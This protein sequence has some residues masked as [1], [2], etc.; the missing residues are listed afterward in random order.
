VTQLGIQALGVAAAFLWAF[1]VSFGIFY[2]IKATVG[3]RVSPEEEREGLDLTEHGV[4][5]YPPG[6]ITGVA[7]VTGERAMVGQ[8][9]PAVENG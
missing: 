5:A 7:P 9:I 6:F 2:A 4:H 8:A 3:L 1:P